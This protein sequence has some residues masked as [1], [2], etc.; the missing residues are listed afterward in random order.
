MTISFIAEVSPIYNLHGQLMHRHHLGWQQLLREFRQLGYLH[1]LLYFNT[2]N[3][4]LISTWI[5]SYLLIKQTV[6]KIFKIMKYFQY[7]VPL[8]LGM[9]CLFYDLSI[10]LPKC[11]R[12]CI[13]PESWYIWLW[14]NHI[15]TTNVEKTTLRAL[16]L[17]PVSPRPRQT[18][19]YT[20]IIAL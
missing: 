15:H 17:F 16:F 11:V 4:C 5:P 1:S 2:L 9:P 14:R 18:P 8:Q 13:K 7:F 3:M 20:C 19:D 10:L 12:S 6:I